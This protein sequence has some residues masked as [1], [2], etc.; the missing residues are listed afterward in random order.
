MRRD[1]RAPEFP[2]LRLRKKDLQS[3]AVLGFMEKLAD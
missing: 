2:M 1:M 3:L